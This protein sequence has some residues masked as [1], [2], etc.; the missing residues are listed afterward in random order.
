MQRLGYI[1]L[2]I[3][4]AASYI[5]KVGVSNRE[6]LGLVDREMEKQKDGDRSTLAAIQTYPES[7]CSIWEMSLGKLKAYDPPAVDL[8]NICSY[9]A[10]ENI[11]VEMLFLGMSQ[12]LQLRKL[13]FC[14]R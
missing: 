12:D 8:L 2:A 4:Q 5:S 11:P 9:F 14:P 7:V 10:C 1:P 6:Y 13:R 3:C